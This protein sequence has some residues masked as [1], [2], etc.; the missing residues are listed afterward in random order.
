MNTLHNDLI[1]DE[2]LVLHPYKDTVG[3]MTIGVGRNIEDRGISYGEAM[4]M[5]ENDIKIVKGEL[6]RAVGGA[7]WGS[8]SDDVQ[9]G[10]LNMAFNLGIPRLLTF[11]K[12]WSALRER[13]YALAAIEALDSK[14]A[15]QVGDRAQRIANLIRNGVHLN[16]GGD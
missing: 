14:W 10:L 12:M 1:R 16:E 8:L 7:F 4:F 11:K 6:E 2:D 5:L 3:K 9:R 13:N 15:V